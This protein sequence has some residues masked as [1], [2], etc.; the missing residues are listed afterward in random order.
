LIIK[1]ILIIVIL[2]SISAF[3]SFN[4][5]VY[6]C[7][8]QGAKKFH[9]SSSCRGLSACKHQINEVSKDKAISMSLTLCGWED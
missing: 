3:S 1:K 4:S 9:Y 7:G 2:V 6:I 8:P 5:K